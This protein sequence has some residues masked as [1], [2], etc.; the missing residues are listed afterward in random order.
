MKALDTQQLLGRNQMLHLA[1]KIRNYH[2]WQCDR[3]VIPTKFV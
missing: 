1:L 2:H 3:S